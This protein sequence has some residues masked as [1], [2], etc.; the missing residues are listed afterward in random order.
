M[1]GGARQPS[2]QVVEQKSIPDE[3]IPFVTDVAAR[4]QAVS[5]EP[6]QPFEGQ[7]VAGFTDAQQAAM[8]NIAGLTR[9]DQLAQARQTYTNIGDNIGATQAG[10]FDAATAQ[11]YMNPY[12]QAVTNIAIR[13]AQEQAQIQANQDLLKS[14]GR[15]TSGGTREAVRQAILGRGLTDKIGDLQAR[16]SDQAFRLAQQQ[17]ERDRA[18]R[19][20]QEEAD[21]RAQF[22][23]ARGLSGLGDLQQRSDLQRLGIQQRTAGLDQALEQRILDERYKDFLRQ[24]DFPKEQLAFYSNIIRGLPAPVSSTQT[25]YGREPSLGQQAAGLGIAGL[26]LAREFGGT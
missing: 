19:L 8:G 24:R 16:G 11:Q 26:G 25:T 6:Y 20:R 3:L 23:V 7:R 18:A 21:R 4:S 1:G 17:F 10:T 15:G 22:G 13:K 9:P 14:A 2:T 5:R 12:Q